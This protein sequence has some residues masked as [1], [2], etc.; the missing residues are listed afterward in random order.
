MNRQKKSFNLMLIELA[1]CINR[2]SAL[3]RRINK[4]LGEVEGVFPFLEGKSKPL[5]HD[6]DSGVVRQLQVVHT[7]HY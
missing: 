6:I 3:L 1:C 5:F 2:F 7:S 4:K